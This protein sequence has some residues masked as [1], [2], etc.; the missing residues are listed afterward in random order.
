L[1]FSA[2]HE[3][4]ATYTMSFAVLALVTMTGMVPI[5]M[6]RGSRQKE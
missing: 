3:V 2:I 1:V 6:M 5:L 4:T